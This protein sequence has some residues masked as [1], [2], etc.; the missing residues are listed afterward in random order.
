MCTLFQKKALW[1]W[2]PTVCSGFPDDGLGTPRKQ[3]SYILLFIVFRMLAPNPKQ[4]SAA[5]ASK[6]LSFYGMIQNHSLESQN[7]SGWEEFLVVSS[8]TCCIKQD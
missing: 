3:G 1:P 4:S 5:Q 6:Q 2:S 7:H 8:P